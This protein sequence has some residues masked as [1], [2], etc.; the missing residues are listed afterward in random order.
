[1][2][3]LTKL[4]KNKELDKLAAELGWTDEDALLLAASNE[5]LNADPTYRKALEDD[6]VSCARVLVTSCRA[7]GQRRTDFREVILQGNKDGTF[8]VKDLSSG[9]EFT[10]AVP[11]LQLLK[12]VKTRWSATFFMINCLLQLWLV[13]PYWLWIF[14]VIKF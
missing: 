11:E 7:S 1:L 8:H 3:T 9:K 6:P 12:D 13:C 10:I 14:L 2:K 4:P 5:A